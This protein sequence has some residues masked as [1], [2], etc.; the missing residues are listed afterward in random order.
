VP[1]EVPR[2]ATGLVAGGPVLAAYLDWRHLMHDLVHFRRDTNLH[3]VN[4]LYAVMMFPSRP[5][6]P[7]RF[8]NTA[9]G[10]VSD[11]LRGCTVSKLYPPAHLVFLLFGCCRRVAGGDVSAQVTA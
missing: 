8:R 7:A 1:P 2:I 11:S 5:E 10:Q 3:Y 9:L 4:A 6:L